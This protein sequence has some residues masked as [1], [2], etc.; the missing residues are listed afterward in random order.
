MRTLVVTAHFDDAEISAGGTIAKYGADLLVLHPR[1]GTAFEGSEAAKVLGAHWFSQHPFGQRHTVN[2]YTNMGYDRIISVS[3]YDSHPDHQKAASIA[4]QI[5]RKNTA[6]LWFMDHAIPGGVSGSAPT[7]SL[8]V[9]ISDQAFQKYEAI[10]CYKSQLKKYGYKWMRR[11][12]DRDLYHGDTIGAAYAE[13]FH[14]E[15]MTL[16]GNK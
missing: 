6:D 9:D 1:E 7:P 15:H 12:S 11:I 10:E 5:A 2:E 4:R 14:V 8:Y 3:P 16:R 13:R